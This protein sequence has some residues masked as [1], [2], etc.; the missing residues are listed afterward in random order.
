M[1]HRIIIGLWILAFSLFPLQAVQVLADEYG[2]TGSLVAFIESDKRKYDVGEPIYITV[3]LTNHTTVSLII[4][5]RLNPL[6]DLQWDLFYETLGGNLSM[7]ESPPI[8]L[9][10][11]DFMRLEVNE[12]LGKRFEDLSVMVDAP[13][14]PGRYAIRLTYKNEE[15]PKGDETWAGLTVTNLLWIE[16]KPSQKI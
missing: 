5:K 7:K 14:K 8:D 4:N 10:T 9:N 11:D 6:L 12:E 15:K 13:L 1:M 3:S 16:I 2:R